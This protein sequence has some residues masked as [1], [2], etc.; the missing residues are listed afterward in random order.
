L[1][2]LLF[3]RGLLGKWKWDFFLG[4]QSSLYRF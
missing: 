4:I 2:F 3:L 1:S